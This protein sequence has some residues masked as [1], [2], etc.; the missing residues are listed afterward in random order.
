MNGAIEVEMPE[1]DVKEDIWE[2]IRPALAPVPAD[3]QKVGVRLK[4]ATANVLTLRPVDERK[5][6]ATGGVMLPGRVEQLEAEFE[7]AGL[8]VVGVEEGRAPD[9]GMRIGKK[10][11]MLR[12]QSKKGSRGVQ[13]WLALNIPYARRG[14]EEFFLSEKDVTVLEA[15]PSLLVLRIHA[16][17]LLCDVVVFHAAV[18]PRVGNEGEQEE[19]AKAWSRVNTALKERPDPGTPF[20][21]FM[22][23]NWACRKR[24]LLR[25]RPKR[26]K[27]RELQRSGAAT[28]VG[29]V[30]HVPTVNL[31]GL[32]IW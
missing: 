32:A 22:R 6:K 21:L 10:Y 7:E 13:C 19:A 16:A 27:R 17:F 4:C 26:P 1:H 24:R 14:D 25:C 9:Q 20:V 18:E 30:G 3:R 31:R 12:C 23:C 2:D 15:S 29:E 5:E 11:L 8:I 28:A